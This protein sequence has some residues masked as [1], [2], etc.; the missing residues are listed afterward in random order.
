[1]W[2]G[3]EAH[4]G[5]FGLNTIDPSVQ[6]TELKCTRVITCFVSRVWR[7]PTFS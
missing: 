7:P 5:D 1:M 3:T 2:G 6:A 4:G